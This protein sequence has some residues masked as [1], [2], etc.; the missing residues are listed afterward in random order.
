MTE[1]RRHHDPYAPHPR[2]APPPTVLPVARLWRLGASET[3][4]GA[5]QRQWD[6]AE[7]ADR[8]TIA[9]ALTVATD[10]E[11]AGEVADVEAMT[12]WAVPQVVAWCKTRDGRARG[13]ALAVEAGRD[14]PRQ[15]LFDKVVALR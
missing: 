10:A 8:E 12:G 13:L 7:P 6:H 1:T 11:L 5:Y 14:N 4:V 9:R 2:V 3:A 15:T